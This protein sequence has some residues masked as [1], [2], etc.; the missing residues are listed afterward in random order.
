MSC[1]IALTDLSIPNEFGKARSIV[2]PL[3]DQERDEVKQVFQ[4]FYDEITKIFPC[5]CGLDDD[6]DADVDD[7]VWSD[8]PLIDNFLVE[9]PV[10]GLVFSRVEESLP[11]IIDIANSLG[12]SLVDWQAERVYQKV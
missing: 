10:I 9:A 11:R 5:I 2:E 12:L 8:G 4:S 7:G 6:G 1:T 3:T